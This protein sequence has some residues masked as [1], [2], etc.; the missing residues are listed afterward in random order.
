VHYRKTIEIQKKIM[1]HNS[2]LED[3]IETQNKFIN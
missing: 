3:T 1:N 2:T